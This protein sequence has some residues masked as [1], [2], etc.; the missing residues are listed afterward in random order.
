MAKP[1][2]NLTGRELTFPSDE[3]IVSKTD[4]KGRVTYANETFLRLAGYEEKMV[5]GAPHSLVRH[6]EMPRCVFKLLWDTILQGEEIFAYVV[7]R[8]MN[9]DH[10]WVFAHVTPSRDP[11]GN[12]V[13]F[14][15]SRR[16]PD[17][18][19]VENTIIPLYRALIN[20]EQK[21]SNAKDG[22]NAGLAMVTN[23]LN[24]KGLGY[25]E[26]IFSL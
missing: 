16:V 2:T 24:E 13:G 21:H 25:D 15:S 10:Y 6:P 14:H 12:V 20:E 11:A 22:M 17:R 7:N 8:S 26:F 1:R 5:I 23:L 3:I 4:L 9:G 18:R 19:V